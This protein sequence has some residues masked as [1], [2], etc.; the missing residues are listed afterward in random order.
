MNDKQFDEAVKIKKLKEQEE[1][2]F[3]EPPR[4]IDKQKVISIF[5]LGTALTMFLCVCL[6]LSVILTKNYFKTSTYIPPT[7]AAVNSNPVI[8][9]PVLTATSIPLQ[10]TSDPFELTINSLS[11][12]LAQDTLSSISFKINHSTSEGNNLCTGQYEITDM[13]QLRMV[14]EASY[15][16]ENNSQ[17][18]GLWIGLVAGDGQNANHEIGDETPLY[19]GN[20][21]KTYFNLVT[22]PQF[23]QV[24]NRF[25]DGVSDWVVL[26]TTFLDIND[27][28]NGGSS[29]G[30]PEWHF[31]ETDTDLTGHQIKLIRRDISKLI[32]QPDYYHYDV[33]W[34]FWEPKEPDE[35]YWLHITPTTGT[36]NPGESQ[37]IQVEF[38]SHSLESGQYMTELLVD[39]G[40]NCSAPIT[41][42]VRLTVVED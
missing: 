15:T 6:G 26:S 39:Y 24:A 14:H 21:G 8:N 22:E 3:I 27:H 31:F 19:D 41:I 29:Q 17:V 42:P 37:T 16:G 7:L 20:V 34:S 30:I 25:T 11:M 4:K 12:E 1:F 32:I 10:V 33:T 28:M 40:E 35:S 5:I 23:R 9:A 36:L 13:T 18:K 2:E 38:S